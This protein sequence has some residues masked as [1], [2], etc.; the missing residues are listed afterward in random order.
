MELFM[1][2]KIE[3][4]LFN[5]VVHTCWNRIKMVRLYLGLIIKKAVI[6]HWYTILVAY[7]K[8]KS[9]KYL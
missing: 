6:I 8:S 2:T 3:L 4:K 9:G 7:I 1:A 5:Y